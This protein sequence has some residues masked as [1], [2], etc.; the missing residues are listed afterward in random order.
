MGQDPAFVALMARVRAGDEE[1]AT[2]VVNRFTHRLIDLARSRLD[3]LLRRKL[4]PED[5][6]QSVYRSFFHHYVEGQYQLESWEGLWGML[7]IMTLRRCGYRRAYFRAACRDVLREAGSPQTDS[8]V[9]DWDVLSRDPTP[10]QAALLAEAVEQLMQG[11]TAR[12][13]EI[14][15]LSLQ[16]YT[17]SE[18][19][20]RV[21]RTERTVQRQ[22]KR[23]RQR[24]EAMH[25]EDLNHEQEPPHV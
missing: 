13:Q 23:V 19:S 15:R 5:I 12:E 24:L 4:D 1:A 25:A 22:L 21:G 3:P 9:T 14:V 2:E 17:S 16:G 6:L 20:A 8:S 11:L 18:I 10:S 7:V